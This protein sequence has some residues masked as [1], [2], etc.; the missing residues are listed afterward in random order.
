MAGEESIFVAASIVSFTA[1][2]V[3]LYLLHYSEKKI[4]KMTWLTGIFLMLCFCFSMLR[5]AFQNVLVWNDLSDVSSAILVALVW[6]TTATIGW[7]ILTLTLTFLRWLV[8]VATGKPP[9]EDED[10]A[11]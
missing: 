11:D 10:E 4:W 9:P 1:C 7:L 8:G 3:F 6:V 5:R 2:A